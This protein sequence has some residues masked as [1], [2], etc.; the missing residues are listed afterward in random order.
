MAL[1]WPFVVLPYSARQR[2]GYRGGLRTNDDGGG[3]MQRAGAPTTLRS[4]V[5]AL[6]GAG[7]AEAAKVAATRLRAVLLAEEAADAP[8]QGPLLGIAAAQCVRL[9]LPE[10]MNAICSFAVYRLGQCGGREVAEM[11]AAAAKLGC[12]HASFFRAAATC[13]AGRPIVFTCLRDIAMVADAFAWALKEEVPGVD[14]A[15]AMQGLGVV[16]LSRLHGAQLRDIVQLLHAAGQSLAAVPLSKGPP[17]HATPVFQSLVVESYALVRGDIWN[18]TAQDIAMAVG[19]AASCWQLVDHLREE[20]LRPFLNDVSQGMESGYWGLNARDIALIAVAYARVGSGLLTA[21][22]A[23][24]MAQQLERQT[25]RLSTKDLSLLLWASTS[26]VDAPTGCG[27]TNF[28]CLAQVATRELRT[29]GLADFSSRD[30]GMCA[31]ALAKIGRSSKDVLDSLADE[32]FRRQ[33]NG[34]A[35]KDRAFLLWSMAKGKIKNQALCRM[36][37]RGLAAEDCADIGRDAAGAALWALA[38]VWWML[39]AGDPWAACLVSVLCAAKP[40]EDATAAADVANC[41]RAVAGLPEPDS[42]V[43]SSLFAAACNLNLTDMSVHELCNLASGLAV[44]PRRAAEES[45]SQKTRDGLFTDC[46]ERI[47]QYIFAGQALSAEDC[48]SLGRAYMHEG[49]PPP[50]AGIPIFLEPGFQASVPLGQACD[51]HEHRGAA[52]GDDNHGSDNHGTNEVVSPSADV[53]CGDTRGSRTKD[54]PAYVEHGECHG[55]H[56]HGHS[57]CHGAHD[58]RTNL[59]FKL[60]NHLAHRIATPCRDKSVCRRSRLDTPD[61]IDGP[62]EWNYIPNAWRDRPE[63]ERSSEI[64]ISSQDEGIQCS[65]TAPSKEFSIDPCGGGAHGLDD[66]LGCQIPSCCPTITALDQPGNDSNIMQLNKHCAYKG[67]C[68]KLKNTFLHIHCDMSDS[69]SEGGDCPVCRITKAK[70]VDDIDS[71]RE[72]MAALEEDDFDVWG[73]PLRSMWPGGAEVAAVSSGDGGCCSLQI[74]TCCPG[75]FD[76]RGLGAD[77][78]APRPHEAQSAPKPPAWTQFQ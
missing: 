42:A 58:N 16:A 35:P 51:Q 63:V 27:D 66:T 70:S 67:H 31:Q 15:L 22:L 46:T 54:A 33:L 8:A 77:T 12:M 9:R 68:V 53:W 28:A 20:T 30:L 40:W 39:P 61:W 73:P 10:T 34:F 24:V 69:D 19:T 26:H 75:T 11:A 49:L 32:V 37:V 38:G 41:F 56:G 18:A 25:K 14:V 29:R 65:R 3:G 23:A 55:E 36:L 52:H 43:W 17:L 44:C 71:L 47:A 72:R 13:C 78:L 6:R 5:M 50:P 4:Q 1:A 48:R 64:I 62:V 74:K 2:S 57:H 76:S 60:D 7:D 59:F 45:C 21:A